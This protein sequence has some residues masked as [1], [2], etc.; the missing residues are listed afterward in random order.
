MFIAFLDVHCRRQDSL[1]EG[2]VW[3]WQK[4]FHVFPWQRGRLQHC[5]Q[6]G[7]R[8]SHVQIDKEILQM[9]SRINFTYT[10]IFMSFYD[11]YKIA[12]SLPQCSDG[13]YSNH[14]VLSIYCR[15]EPLSTGPL[16]NINEIKIEIWN[17]LWRPMY[18]WKPLHFCIKYKHEYK[19]DRIKLCKK[20]RYGTKLKWKGPY[21]YLKT[22]RIYSYFSSW[23]HIKCHSEIA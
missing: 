23:F 17:S 5:S 16:V 3:V 10:F 1:P 22:L 8:K 18:I 12:L 19:I 2:A 4:G 21:R 6:R 14:P 9:K 11:W 15:F 13:F 7:L 20:R